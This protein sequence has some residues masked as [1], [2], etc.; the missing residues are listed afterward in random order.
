MTPASDP[1][2]DDVRLAALSALCDGEATP[3]EARQ[4]F[5]DWRQDDAARARWHGYQWI[6]DVMRSEDLA[7]DPSHDE[8]FLQRLRARMADEP[9][10][11]APVATPAQSPKLATAGRPLPIAV[12]RAR[13][14]APA[15]M[16]AGVMVV[17][18][19]LLVLRSEGPAVPAGST[20]VA[21]GGADVPVVAVSAQAPAAASA[22]PLLPEAAPMLRNAEIDR[23]LSAHRQYVASPSLALPGGVRQVAVGAEGR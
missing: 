15:A 21:G 3:G 10:V 14:G 8:A 19:A 13:W 12:R 6:G 5:E 7:S 4:C 1:S 11:L 17:S 16:A 2:S 18:G 23:Y 9:V 22:V 20:V